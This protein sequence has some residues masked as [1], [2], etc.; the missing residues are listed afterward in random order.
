MGYKAEINGEVKQIVWLSTKQ[1]AR[2]FV[3]MKNQKAINSKQLKMETLKEIT[4][5]LFVKDGKPL[6]LANNKS[7]ESIELDDLKE[8]FRPKSTTN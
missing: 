1:M 7:V 3:T 5:K 4:E 2:E 8:I 6:K